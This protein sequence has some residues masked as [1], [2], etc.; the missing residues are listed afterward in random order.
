MSFILL[1]FPNETTSEKIRTL[2]LR[3]GFDDVR[4]V[5]GGGEALR[6][7]SEENTGLLVCPVRM[8]DTDYV[9]VLHRMS[10]FYEILLLDSPRHISERKEEDVMALSAPIHSADLIETV[11]MMLGGLEYVYRQEKKKEKK[12][13]KPKPRSAED[14]KLL[15]EAK[16]LIMERNHMS[17]AEAFRFMQKNSM[18]MGRSMVETA[19]MILAF[20]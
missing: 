1:A 7:M 17:E 20:R 18:D 9:H 10:P 4:I 11:D 14:Q 13:K 2:L 15:D 5:S 19:Q 16:L 8:K 3:H 6:E 12:N